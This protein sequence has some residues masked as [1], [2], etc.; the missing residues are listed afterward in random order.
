MLFYLGVLIFVGHAFALVASY[1]VSG[2]F[3]PDAQIGLLPD[4]IT[5]GMAIVDGLGA[6]VLAMHCLGLG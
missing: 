2:M 1:V 6:I 5:P 4:W 3:Y